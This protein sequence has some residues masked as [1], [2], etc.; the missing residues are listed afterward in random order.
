MLAR[1]MKQEW[2]RIERSI[3]AKV[4]D[5]IGSLQIVNREGITFEM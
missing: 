5:G 1:A 4:G 3:E 2:V